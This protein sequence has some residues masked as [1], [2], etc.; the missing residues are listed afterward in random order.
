MGKGRKNLNIIKI[1]SMENPI[2]NNKYLVLKILLALLPTLIFL[3]NYS[4]MTLN[5]YIGIAFFIIWALMI[6]SVWQLMEKNHILERFFRLTEISFF[7]L[8]LSG[9]IFTF[10]LGARAIS[11]TSNE[12]AQAGA[13]IG[14]AIGGTFV[15]VL[16]FMIGIAGGIIM[17][18]VANKYD[19]KAEASGV[20]EKDTLSNKH[21]LILPLVGIIVLAII[22]GSVASTQGGIKGTGQKN[23]LRQAGSNSVSENVANDKVD[24]EVI[25][26]GFKKADFMVSEFQDKI[27]M[28]IKFTNKT[29]KDIRGVEGVIT[30]YDIFDKVIQSTPISY[31][32]GV[33]KNSSKN[34]SG[35]KDYNQFIDSDVKLNNTDLKN[36]KYEWKVKTIVY[37]DGT[38][39]SF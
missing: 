33:P 17:H 39:E 1:K 30:F 8:P 10:V 12:F 6:W 31:D 15:V 5:A 29:D 28:T 4:W 21:G 25:D 18:L 2:K 32:E 34:W 35:A 14:T 38:K 22:L 36:L 20:K 26:K 3:Q 9:L 11:S 7:F 37:A 13:A 27:T 24:I 23:N 16:S 19:K